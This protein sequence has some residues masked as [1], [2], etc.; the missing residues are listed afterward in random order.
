MIAERK[1]DQLYE[2]AIFLY[3]KNNTLS[4]K[5]GFVAIFGDSSCLEVGST[6]DTKSCIFLLEALLE[7]ALEGDL[8]ES[9]RQSL[10][11]AGTILSLK[12]SQ[13]LPLPKR[14]TTSNFAK[15]SKVIMGISADAEPVYREHPKCRI[16]WNAISQP[17]ANVTL[18]SDLSDSHLKVDRSDL[19]DGNQFSNELTS[20]QLHEIIQFFDA[21]VE[22]DVE[23]TH[24]LSFNQQNYGFLLWGIIFFIIIVIYCRTVVRRLVVRFRIFR[25]ILRRF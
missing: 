1:T 17:V 6:S 4:K 2:E 23:Q 12:Y 18:S 5:S 16:L 21:N 13:N 7:S 14:L 10:V 19:P 24:Q 15:Y 25:F 8:I 22:N 3:Y 20:A 9:L 11:P